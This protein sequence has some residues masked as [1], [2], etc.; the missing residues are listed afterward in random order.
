MKRGDASWILWHI[1]KNRSY[2]VIL[3]YA[4]RDIDKKNVMEI[5]FMNLIFAQSI[6]PL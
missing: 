3:L 2:F 4:I 6:M 5:G 1:R